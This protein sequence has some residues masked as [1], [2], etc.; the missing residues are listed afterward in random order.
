MGRFKVD[1]GDFESEL[2]LPVG[3][4]DTECPTGTPSSASDGIYMF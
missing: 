1:K 3:D 4:L 2:R